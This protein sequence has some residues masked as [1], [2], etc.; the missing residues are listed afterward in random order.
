MLPTDLLQLF[1]KLSMW[2]TWGEGLVATLDLFILSWVHSV[3]STINNSWNMQ[4]KPVTYVTLSCY[5]S[6]VYLAYRVADEKKDVV[7]FVGWLSK[8]SG[9]EQ[10]A[11]CFLA[12]CNWLNA[13]NDWT[14]SSWSNQPAALSISAPISAYSMLL[15]F[16]MA[17]KAC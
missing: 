17:Q 15:P 2:S 9:S 4:W 8:E 10:E 13:L 6:T 11:K 1:A 7:F 5:V 3:A 16:K 14:L 12:G